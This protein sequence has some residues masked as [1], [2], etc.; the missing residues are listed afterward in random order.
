MR[1][2]KQGFGNG[3]EA[4]NRR[5]R[6]D[7][8]DWKFRVNSRV[9]LPR[10]RALLYRQFAQCGSLLIATKGVSLPD[11]LKQLARNWLTAAGFSKERC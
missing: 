5:Q 8:C 7:L 11:L 9:E 1:D 4:V 6:N 2:T 3:P 10:N